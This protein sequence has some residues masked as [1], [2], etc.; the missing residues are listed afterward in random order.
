MPTAVLI[1]P[2]STYRAADFLAAAQTLH[3][4]VVVAT[5]GSQALAGQMG[6]RLV[7][8][9][10][11]RPEWSADRVARLEGIDAVVPVDDQGV[12]V[13][14]L[15]AARLG[16]AHNPPD[17]VAATRDKSAMRRRFAAAGVA[18]P[19]FR[20][21]GGPED[22]AATVAAE[23]GFPVVVKPVSLSASRGV[24]RA[25]DP[26]EAAAAAARIRRMVGDPA[27]P[28]LVERFTDGPEYAVEGLVTEGRVTVLATFDKPD[29]LDG[30]YFEETLLVSPARVSPQVGT[31]LAE[32]TQAAVTALGLRHG[33]VHAELRWHRGAAVVL[34]VAAR[35]IGGLCGRALRFGLLGETLETVLLRHAL[36]IPA[37][38]PS[39]AAPAAGAM[40]LPIPRAGTLVTV[41][42]RAAA[43]AVPGIVGVEVTIAPGRPVA[44][45]PEGDRYLGFLIARGRDGDEVERALRAAHA[46][47]QVVIE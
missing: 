20:V 36:G 5:E 21:A 6:D 11:R 14:A 15:A 8:I 1:L 25:D 18:Q 27:A 45:L 43:A 35:S 4:D 13:A 7:R 39:P 30:P 33:P 23:L 46:W 40:M 17:A 9:D 31:A 37:R 22:D 44:P 47:L 16:L 34:E 38:A 32:T 12:E 28:L 41:E 29:P 10:C 19:A 26:A 2:S 42:G 24:I 3:A